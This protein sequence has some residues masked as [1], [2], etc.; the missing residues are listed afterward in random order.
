MTGRKWTGAVSVEQLHDA[1]SQLAREIA[2]IDAAI[3]QSRGTAA[4]ELVAVVDGKRL[5][6]TILDGAIREAGAA[7]EGS[8]G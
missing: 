8:N 2:A 4:K 7:T 5:I 6:V 1:R 3:T